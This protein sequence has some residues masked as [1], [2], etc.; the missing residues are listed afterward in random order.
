[1]GP[2]DPELITLKAARILRQVDTIAVPR[3]KEGGE[4]L[5]LS[6][7]KGAALAK[8]TALAEGKTIIE[9]HFPMIR[10]RPAPGALEG[11]ARRVLDILEQGRDVAFATL[12]DPAIY[13]TF[14]HLYDAIL[15][16]DPGIRAEIIPAVSS[17]NASSALARKCLALSGE[18]IAVIPAP[19]MREPDRV[20]GLFETVV[21]MKVNSVFDEVKKTLTEAGLLDRAVYVSRAGLPGEIIK[22][23]AEVLAE[24]LDYFSTII[25]RT[26]PDAR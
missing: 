6:I 15:A 18:K 13:S 23:V 9:L 14:F 10:R 2:G 8:G 4:S 3:G 21:L 25:V 16:L 11:Q 20:F 17:I 22:P 26:V 24:D 12:G 19:Y 1:V 5:A 7:I